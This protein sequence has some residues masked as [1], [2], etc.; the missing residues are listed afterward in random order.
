MTKIWHFIGLP[1]PDEPAE[2]SVSKLNTTTS[3]ISIDDSKPVNTDQT[4][5]PIQMEHWSGPITPDGMPFHDLG[6]SSNSSSF[7]R[8]D[9]PI[10][11]LRY[12][13]PN[14][15]NRLPLTDMVNRLSQG[16]V[17]FVDLSVMVHMDAHQRACRQSLKQLSNERRLPVFAL[18]DSE[19]L[20]M[21]AGRDVQIDAK[22]HELR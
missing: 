14:S 10:R 15:L 7:A 1:D 12:V 13:T 2:T 6:D 5:L 11:S 16:D 4:Q 3:R 17:I 21:L 22:L 8:E 19:S 20:L 9:S 18:D